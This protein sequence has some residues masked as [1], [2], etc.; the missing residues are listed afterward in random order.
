M[1][2]VGIDVSR[3][4]SMIAVLWRGCLKVQPFM[5]YTVLYGFMFCYIELPLTLEITVSKA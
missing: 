2:A 3:G 5:F 1:T 4:K